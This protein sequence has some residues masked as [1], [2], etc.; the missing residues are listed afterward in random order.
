[1]NDTGP[2]PLR[3][4][5]RLLRAKYPLMR[6]VKVSCKKQ[7]DPALSQQ[8]AEEILGLRERSY[9]PFLNGNSLC[10]PFT[11]SEK[12][13]EH[14]WFIDAF[15]MDPGELASC[16]QGI[17]QRG[18]PQPAWENSLKNLSAGSC[19]TMLVYLAVHP[20]HGMHFFFPYT[21]AKGGKAGANPCHMLLLSK[22]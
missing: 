13:L 6:Y 2:L 10:S 22:A 16:C 20:K 3:K 7:R 1:V 12:N 17:W 11:Y 9:K 8:C 19:P 5:W 18:V 15:T 14:T 4:I 21:G